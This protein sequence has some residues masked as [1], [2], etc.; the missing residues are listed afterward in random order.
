MEGRMTQK[1]LSLLILLSLF[2]QPESHAQWVQTAGPYGG[3]HIYAMCV[4]GAKIFAGTD[5]G[6][7]L[8]TNG[9]AS[10]QARGL[11]GQ[12]VVSLVHK[13]SIIF[14]AVGT[15]GIFLSTDDGL[16]WQYGGLSGLVNTI[17]VN[18]PNLFAGT[19]HGAF[20]STDNGGTWQALNNGLPSTNVRSLAVSD[21]ILLAGT[22]T[23]GVFLSTI[24]GLDWHAANN[25]ITN[26]TVLS[27]GFDGPTFLAGTNEG[28]VFR[29]TDN[30]TSWQTINNGFGTIAVIVR[31]IAASAAGI[32]AATINGVFRS[33]DHGDSWESVNSGLRPHDT[34]FSLAIDSSRI[35]AGGYSGLF[36]S[37]NS[38][39]SWQTIGLYSE[40]TCMTI[41]GSKVFAGTYVAG[42]Q[43]TTD[44]GAS[45]RVVDNE[46]FRSGD[47]MHSVYANASI[48]LASVGPYVY[49]STNDGVSWTKSYIGISGFPTVQCFVY[50]DSLFFAGTS[51]AGVF[52]SSDLGVNWQYSGLNGYEVNSL[53]V[54][55]SSVVAGTYQG[56]FR[57]SD[58]GATW[59]E[60]DSGIAFPRIEDLTLCGSDI[61]AGTYDEGIFRS[62]DGGTTWSVA[63]DGMPATEITALVSQGT[64]LFAGTDG[65]GVFLSTDAGVS[66]GAVNTGLTNGTV[67]CLSIKGSNI[68]AGTWGGGVL[69]RPLSEMIMTAINPAWPIASKFSL[70]QN[71][72]NPFN[73]ITTI[74]FSIPS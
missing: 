28:G 15:I 14:A 5:N 39:D 53:L 8:S 3:S 6:V 4:Q 17:V 32:F 63:S 57:S 43:S 35:F 47:G 70:A 65:S 11:A 13:D 30:G 31:A 34:F 18:G 45:W 51:W 46:L 22:T 27:L 52:V 66:W 69:R 7:F 61:F 24:N 37:T 25:G 38:G 55:G 62:R 36:L 41:S 26:L 9:G 71:Y 54:R 44:E 42:L 73:P 58:G 29:S 12:Y 56:I 33:T 20:L 59:Q 60:S 23:S 72:P 16:T 21:L 49:R 19:D 1:I 48:I 2:T 74:S 68:F 40:V 50:N 67:S 10:W 64:S